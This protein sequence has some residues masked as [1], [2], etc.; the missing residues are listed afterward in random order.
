VLLS[1]FCLPCTD[2]HSIASGDT[3][4]PL[5]PLTQLLLEL[6]QASSASL[7][8]FQISLPLGS[9]AAAKTRHAAQVR[10]C[11]TVGCTSPRSQPRRWSL[12]V[13]FIQLMINAQ[14]AWKAA[15]AT[16]THCVQYLVTR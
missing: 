1:R 4:R 3:G 8:A 10:P 6:T 13:K 15:M 16:A 5:Q 2:R 11:K 14:G 12:F 7:T 9:N